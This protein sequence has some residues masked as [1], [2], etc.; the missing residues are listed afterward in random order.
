MR[1]KQQILFSF[2]DIATKGTNNEKSKVDASHLCSYAEVG[3]ADCS[4][5]SFKDGLPSHEKLLHNR[6]VHSS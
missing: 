5:I 6:Y 1:I 4:Q 2:T 3:L